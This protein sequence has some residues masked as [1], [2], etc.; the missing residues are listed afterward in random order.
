MTNLF[1]FINAA[2]DYFYDLGFTESANPHEPGT[3]WI[4]LPLQP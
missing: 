2:H 3:R 4:E 1:Y